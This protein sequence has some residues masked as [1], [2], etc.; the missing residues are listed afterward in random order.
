MGWDGERGFGGRQWDGERGFGWGPGCWD[1]P[2]SLASRQR[3]WAEEPGVIGPVSMAPVAQEKLQQISFFRNLI[4]SRLTRE[5][6]NFFK[7]GIF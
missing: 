7:M 4:I 3:L 5:V 2:M 1:V 6:I